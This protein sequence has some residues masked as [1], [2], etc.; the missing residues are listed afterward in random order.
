[1]KSHIVALVPMRHHSERLT[2]KNY[3]SFAGK[4]LYHY[5]IGSLSSCP[6][7]SRVVIDT[8]STLIM[9]DTSKYFPRV[10]LIERPDHLRSGTIPMNDVL[11][12]DV[13]QVKADFYL[14]THST[15]PLIR[16]E[17]VT[18]AII[19]FLDSYPMYDSLFS[20]TRVNTRL[21]D[22]QARAINHN[23]KL[24]LRTQDLP[25]VYEENSCLYIFSRTTLET[26]KNRIGERPLMFETD[27]I[28]GWDIDDE[29][30]FRL[31][32]YLYKERQQTF[33]G[34]GS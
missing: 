3:R 2:E 28:E 20:V 34:D 30:D 22:S 18:Q 14:Q 9:E 31:A 16:T 4:P 17:T 33:Q 10:Q 8:D 25:P 19:R 1:M 29:L 24:L 27:R 5:I 26:R 21:W 13:T 32:E 23:P 11:L 12:Y 6:Y 7:I 15:N